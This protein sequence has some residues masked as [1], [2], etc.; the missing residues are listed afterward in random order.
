M[1]QKGTTIG[2]ASAHQDKASQISSPKRAE[3]RP[4][5]LTTPIVIG[6]PQICLLL[7]CAVI[8]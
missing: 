4:T 8:I 6:M 3:I 1:Y 5:V 2:I 7:K